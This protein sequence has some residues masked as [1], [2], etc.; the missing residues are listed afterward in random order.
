MDLPVPVNVAVM[1]VGDDAAL[2]V[3]VDRLGSV[4]HHVVEVQQRASGDPVL[5]LFSK[6]IDDPEIDVVIAVASDTDPVRAAISPLITRSLPGFGELLRIAAF[7][8]I[9]SSAM[10]LDAEAARCG[11]TYLFVIPGA[12]GA[13]KVALDR[14]LIPQLDL[15]TRPTSLAAKLPRLRAMVPP[16]DAFDKRPGT[17]PGVAPAPQPA[18]SRTVPPGPPP[19]TTPPLGVVLRAPAGTDSGD[20]PLLNSDA[21]IPIQPAVIVEDKEPSKTE[22]PAVA[23]PRT[24]TDELA[25]EQVVEAA[26]QEPAAE[27]PVEAKP[28]PASQAL[29]SDNVG[30]FVRSLEAHAKDLREKSQVGPLPRAPGKTEPPRAPGKTEPP[31]LPKKTDAELKAARD[32]AVTEAISHVGPRPEP[33]KP[34]AAAAAAAAAAEEPPPAPPKRTKNITTRA[35]WEKAAD[36]ISK[37]STKAPEP[38]LAELDKRAVAVRAP[39]KRRGALLVPLLLG[40]AAAGGYVV[41]TQLASNGT[42]S[43]QPQQV[44][45]VAPPEQAPA[46]QPQ[47]AP[48]P[49][50]PEP[51]VVIDVTDTGSSSPAAAP[52]L[53]AVATHHH[54]GSAA[55][56]A[57][58]TASETGSDAGSAGPIDPRT[59]PNIA[60]AS[61]DCDETS[62]IL[63]K[64]ARECCARY[65]P[66]EMP[67]DKIDPPKPAG[68]PDTLDKAA[69][70]AGIAD[71]KPA[72][73]QCGE[74]HY[75]AGEVKITLTVGADGAVTDATVADSPDP[76]LGKCVAGALK[77]AT[78]AKTQNGAVFTYPFAF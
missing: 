53:T 32:A 69:V 47:T 41:K 26:P 52:T 70:K 48:P 3:V 55:P 24:T 10:T 11:G 45:M 29:T 75:H 4:G 33:P 66:A 77:R 56:V 19:R 74:D 18:P 73:Q 50:E 12:V 42:A 9:G 27:Q 44:A 31:P 67:V 65:K 20:I 43:A 78:F 14:L 46:Q 5:E 68:P 7:G 54:T 1:C 17:D 35:E 51:E 57:H 38:T 63:E 37:Q 59:H 21:A 58:E 60:P 71:V 30:A 36:A 15:R 2:N 6:W 76:E 8:E 39:K 25:P 62:C 49:V 40:V 23:L 16:A 72:V 61:P 13:V 64:Y 22:E 34:E 28:E